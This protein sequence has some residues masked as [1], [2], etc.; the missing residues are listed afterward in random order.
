MWAAKV[1]LAFVHLAANASKWFIAF[2]GFREWV[3]P[4]RSSVA[5]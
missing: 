2:L 3:G 4:F 5:L 1:G